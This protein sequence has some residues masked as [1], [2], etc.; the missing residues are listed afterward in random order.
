MEILLLNIAGT[1]ATLVGYLAM[2]FWHDVSRD[3]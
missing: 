2:V 1:L 3:S